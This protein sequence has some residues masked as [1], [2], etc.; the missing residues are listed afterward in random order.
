MKAQQALE[1]SFGD[2]HDTWEK[3][4]Q[5]YEGASVGDDTIKQAVIMASNDSSTS[6]ESYSK[7]IE[8]ALLKNDAQQGN[9]SS[10]TR[11]CMSKMFPVLRVVLEAVSFS[12][13]VCQCRSRIRSNLTSFLGSQLLTT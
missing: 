4:A 1:T 3:S 7:V 6:A 8:K 12:A 5:Y 10:T 11:V 2:L 13:D 9:I